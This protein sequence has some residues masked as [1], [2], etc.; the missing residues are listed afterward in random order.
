MISKLNN[1]LPKTLKHQEI[2]LFSLLAKYA[3]S[4]NKN[5]IWPLGHQKQLY[6]DDCLGPNDIPN[7]RQLEF[8]SYG[9]L[10]LTL[11]YKPLKITPADISYQKQ[12]MLMFDEN[13]PRWRSARRGISFKARC[14]NRFCE[15]GS[16]GDWVLVNKGF[17]VFSIGETITSLRC[18]V[19]NKRVNRAENCG[20][21]DC[22]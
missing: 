4:A 17:G 22:K 18:P 12:V 19:C 21:F 7:Y 10:N 2:G 14:R 1:F 3:N 9:K 8:Q 16:M 5:L 15:A 11:N 6:S 13:A 20:F